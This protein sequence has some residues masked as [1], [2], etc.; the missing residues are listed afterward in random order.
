MLQKHQSILESIVFAVPNERFGE[1]VGV[2]IHAKDDHSLSNI[3]IIEFL[4]LELI[5]K[6]L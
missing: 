1:E 6:F 2:C 4:W 5:L 3:S